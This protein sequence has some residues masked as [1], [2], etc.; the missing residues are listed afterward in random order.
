MEPE[1]IALRAAT[2][3]AA[4]VT[5]IENTCNNVSK[6]ALKLSESLA[7]Q[8][9]QND[10]IAYLR[11]LIPL[12]LTSIEFDGL[13][14]FLEASERASPYSEYVPHGQQ[15]GTAAIEFSNS[16]LEEAAAC[17]VMHDHY[18]PQPEVAEWIGK[19]SEQVTDSCTGITI[20]SPQTRSVCCVFLLAQPRRCASSPPE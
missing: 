20:S 16:V 14:P 8:E 7:R 11:G 18:K 6:V 10:P 2:L 12:A 13:L 19:V 1:D 3:D 4:I 15:L 9:Y 17:G 5:A